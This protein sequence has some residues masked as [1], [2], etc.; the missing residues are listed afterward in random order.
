MVNF[1]YSWAYSNA[2][3]SIDAINTSS[4]T[5]TPLSGSLNAG[6]AC[7]ASSSNQVVITNAFTT[8]STGIFSLKIDNVLSIPLSY[9]SLEVTASTLN[10]DGS[11]I[12]GNT[13]CPTTIPNPRS[14]TVI[15]TSPAQTVSTSFSFGVTFNL[16]VPLSS[17]DSVVFTIPSAFIIQ[18]SS[19]VLASLTGCSN[20]QISPLSALTNATSGGVTNLTYNH[21]Y[22]V[23]NY[24]TSCSQTIS[25]TATLGS[26]TLIAPPSTSP[27]QIFLSLLR[28][29][30]IYS[31]G[32]C[33][34][35]ASTN[36]LSSVTISS[37]V[38]T[39]NQATNFVITF[40]TAS[41]LNVGS[42]VVVTLPSNVQTST[43]TGTC[44][45][46]TLNSTSVTA[47]CALIG[48]T[49][50]VTNLGGLDKNTTV[51][52][53]FAG[54]K[55]PGTT[56]TVT[57]GIST[58]YSDGFAVDTFSS[59]TYAA[60]PDTIMIAN[61]SSASNVTGQTSMYTLSY[62]VKNPLPINS[63]IILGIPIGLSFSSGVACTYSINGG[64]YN[65]ITP[66]I[67]TSGGP[68]YNN[69]ASF[70]IPVAATSGTVLSFRI[71]SIINPLTTQ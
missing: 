59:L 47:T 50:T 27:S 60:L 20:S 44:V 15:S 16:P 56:E 19:G 58:F 34:L 41:A 26:M 70:V 67:L 66:T 69:G 4:P 30:H 57:F 42:S 32:S 6:W 24:L 38:H 23:P 17:G 13:V 5:C 46:A 3:N 14:I 10:A 12:D 54:S 40:V 55:N 64:P 22:P 71:S 11:V 25:I 62:T 18:N 51:R 45:S 1:P 65:S 39:I 68:N 33:T 37:S 2:N 35:T 61:V 21:A 36:T 7:T 53:E 29:G 52:I 8:N 48:T 9:S 28:A 49:L 43:S 31:S 63:K